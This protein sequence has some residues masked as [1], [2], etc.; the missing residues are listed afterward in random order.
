MLTGDGG[1][2]YSC[3]MSNRTGL[4]EQV[5]T[6]TRATRFRYLVLLGLVVITV[7]NY[8]DR[9][10]I[11][12]AA[13]GIIGEYSLD[14]IAWGQILG[15][16]G[17]GYMF[18]ALAG[19]FLADKKGPK[20]TMTAACAA[21]SVLVIAVVSAGD[22]GL[23]LFGS[24]LVGFAIFRIGFGFAEGPTYATINRTVA[25]WSTV[26]ERGF[27]SAFG[28]LGTPLGALLSAPVAVGLITLTGGWR[29]MFVVLGVLGLAWLLWWQ[30]L[31]TNK[32]EDNPRVN[33]QELAQIRT[34]DAT[35]GNADGFDGGANA[36]WYEFFLSKT[37]IFNALGYFSFM[38]VNFM[39]LTWT[40]RY[41]ESEFG[42]KLGSLWY[43]GMVPWI[44]AC[45]TVV[46]GGKISDW[47]RQKT[48]SLWI[49]RSGFAMLSLAL[50]TVCF[51][52]IP[53]LD[54]PAAVL[55]V[56]ALGNALNSLPNAVY[57]TVL[58]D[59]VPAKSA[60]FAGM[61]HFFANIATVVAPTLTG[62]LVAAHGFD[63]MFIATAVA[64]CIGVVAMAFV[65]PG[66]FRRS[67]A[68]A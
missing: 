34:A 18:G 63:S 33:S 67:K 45:F 20:W 29:W 52:F 53:T 64:T 40:P 8:V 49:A 17:Y 38:Y 27:M 9:G 32:P 59:T 28:L 47:L 11:A 10:A 46:L 42:F 3:D 44:G 7:V 61:T 56:M 39:I 31:F 16:F 6:V 65:Q 5:K 23:Q 68:T 60:S 1:H 51:C 25:N 37:L 57:W 4:A 21:W 22:V 24:A 66:R 58:I 15:F 30:L 26:K 62:F 35:R 13:S 19:G 50:T 14:P 43:L 36:K 48:G 55:L 12:Y 2:P 54:S 41:L